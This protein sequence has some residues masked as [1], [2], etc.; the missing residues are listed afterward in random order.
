MVVNQH[1]GVRTERLCSRGV[2]S[3]RYSDVWKLARPFQ[4]WPRSVPFGM[5]T[6]MFGGSFDNNNCKIHAREMNQIPRDK[7]RN[8]ACFNPCW[9]LPTRLSLVLRISPLR[10]LFDGT[11]GAA[12]HR[13]CFMFE[14]G[15][16]FLDTCFFPC[17]RADQIMMKI[18]MKARSIAPYHGTVPVD[19]SLGVRVLCHP[20]V[21]ILSIMKKSQYNHDGCTGI[22]PTGFHSSIRLDRIVFL[23]SDGPTPEIKT[24]IST[25]FLPAGV[26]LPFTTLLTFERHQ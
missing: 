10:H 12:R 6:R 2:W 21:E 4:T 14:A 7:P 25:V 8:R 17:L 20:V 19:C 23:Y 11:H 13:L 18:K 9:L 22:G 15:A 16:G 1:G 3:R 24:A 26:S 5:A